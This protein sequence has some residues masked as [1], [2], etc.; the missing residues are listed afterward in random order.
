VTYGELA[1]RRRYKSHRSTQPAHLERQPFGQADLRLA[2]PRTIS[3]PLE[4]KPT[5]PLGGVDQVS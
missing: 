1:A 2:M 4:D 5:A 3:N